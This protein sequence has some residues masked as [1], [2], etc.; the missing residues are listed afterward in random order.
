M[1]RLFALLLVSMLFVLSGA[2]AESAA[3]Q[4]QEMYSQAELAMALG[5]YAGAAENESGYLIAKRMEESGS[6]EE[7][8]EAYGKLGE[9]KDSADCIERCRE[10]LYKKALESEEKKEYSKAHSIYA[11]LGNYK[12][13]MERR[14]GLFV[15][16]AKYVDSS[17]TI[18]YTYDDNNVLIYAKNDSEKWPYEITYTYEDGKLVS[19]LETGISGRTQAGEVSPTYEKTI[20]YDEWGNQTK[21]VRVSTD[22]A[23]NKDAIKKHEETYEYVYDEQGHILKGAIYSDGEFISEYTLRYVFDEFGRIAERYQT[24]GGVEKYKLIYTYN[25]DGLLVFVDTVSLEKGKTTGRTT[26]DYQMKK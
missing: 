5:D 3:E 24:T 17:S 7:A 18:Y 15:V 19:S 13:C 9:Y 8:I 1:K 11:Y 25:E 6:Y 26:Y 21:V 16:T 20:Y 23:Y 22:L 12:D 14:A 10:A 2:A 4:L